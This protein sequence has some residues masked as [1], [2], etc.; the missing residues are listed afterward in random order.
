MRYTD[1]VYLEQVT[2]NTDVGYDENGDLIA[3]PT[4]TTN[5]LVLANVLYL[6]AKSKQLIYGTIDIHAIKVILIPSKYNGEKYLTYGG[7]R[8]IVT[9]TEHTHLFTQLL[10]RQVGG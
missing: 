2:P 7:R 1:K 4:T 5:K 10:G 8:Y 6:K 3:P 9:S